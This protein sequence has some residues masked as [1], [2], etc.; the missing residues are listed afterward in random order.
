ME[1]SA[2]VLTTEGINALVEPK[3]YPILLMDK[4]RDKTIGSNQFTKFD[5]KNGYY[6]IRIKE[7][8]EWKTTFKTTL[9][10][11]EYTF[12]PFGLANAPATF[13]AMIDK[14]LEELNNIEVYYF[15]DVTIHTKGSLEDHCEGV[16]KV[17]K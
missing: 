4:L 12:M 13:Q 14:V 2:S 1:C 5:L 16:Q 17:P 7:G 9:G 8:D 11:F 10:L 6:L 3:W 15:D